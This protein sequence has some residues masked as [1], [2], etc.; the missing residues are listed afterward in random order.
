MNIGE[1]QAVKQVEEPQM[2]PQT[3]STP[4]KAVL[5]NDEISLSLTQTEDGLFVVE[6][7]NKL[8][9]NTI[10]CSLI[11]TDDLTRATKILRVFKEG[12]RIGST[13]ETVI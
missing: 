2:L 4:Q 13:T 12:V 5:E 1:L 8:D 9:D 11:E 10:G 3:I 6:C 7:N